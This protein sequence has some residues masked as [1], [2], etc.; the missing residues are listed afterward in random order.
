MKTTLLVI[1]FLLAFSFFSA[2][3]FANDTEQKSLPGYLVLKEGEDSNPVKY[4]KNAVYFN[5]EN[6]DYAFASDWPEE[7]VLLIQ[8]SDSTVT[9]IS[10]KHLFGDLVEGFGKELAAK[11]TNNNGQI[12][13]ADSDWKS[14]YIWEDK[15]RDGY[16]QSDELKLLSSI[17]SNIINLKDETAVIDGETYSFYAFSP[18]Y[19]KINTRYVKDFQLDIDTLFMPTLRGYG[20]LPDLH[21]AA[22]ENAVL[23]E[24]LIQLCSVEIDKIFT[25]NYMSLRDKA[26]NILY[27]HANVENVDP[28]SRGPNI[29]ARQL[30]ILE[31]VMN[32]PFSGYVNKTG[33]EKSSN[34]N[35]NAA[36]TLQKA[37][38]IWLN[39]NAALLLMQCK[40]GQLFSPPITYNLS[41]DSTS[42]GMKHANQGTMQNITNY[43]DGKSDADNAMF[44]TMME[45]FL[46]S[47]DTDKVYAPRLLE[48]FKNPPV[49]LPQAPE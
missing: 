42:L 46:N 31:K 12:D 49:D 27:L 3:S 14:L 7:G 39:R 1:R 17:S 8:L 38:A 36:K 25:S 29:D 21:I 19:D 34:P 11:D 47:I 16:I 43:L 6:A 13:S 44:W 24:A 22:S 20:G 28:K 40:A 41:N 23:K 37:W 5:W 10:E 48:I 33:E 30:I 32:K 18:L 35:N 45:S 4:K 26:T 15:N 9:A 2:Q